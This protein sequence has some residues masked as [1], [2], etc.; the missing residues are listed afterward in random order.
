M[1]KDNVVVLSG[2][3]EYRDGVKD[4]IENFL[5][6]DNICV[7]EADHAISNSGILERIEWEHEEGKNIIIV[8]GNRKEKDFMEIISY[9]TEFFIKERFFWA[10]SLMH[11]KELKL[12]LV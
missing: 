10:R 6:L 9:T 2:K 8:G 12:F 7:V 1:K 5:C 11:I 4:F 3:E